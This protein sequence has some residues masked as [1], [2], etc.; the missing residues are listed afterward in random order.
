MDDARPRKLV[1]LDDDPTGSQTVAGVPLL[2]RF[3][4]ADVHWALTQ[5][6]DIVF[7][8]TNSRAMGEDEAVAVTRAVGA[9]VWRAACELGLDVRFLSRGDS[10]LRGHFPAEVEA[11]G[12]GLA[13]AGAPPFDATLL[14]P[15]FPEA[16]RV[17]VGDVHYVERDG[18]R[19]PVAQT[20]FA[21][22]PVFGYASSDLCAWVAE[23]YHGRRAAPRVGHV[24][25]AQVR[26][27]G[28][29]A[30][31]RHL[32]TVGDGQVVVLNAETTE[33]LATL[34]AGARVAEHRGR[35]FA[36]RTGPS[37]VAA[38]AGRATPAPIALP[39]QGDGHGLVVV[40][41]HTALT[42]AQLAHARARHGLREV[43][44]DV[45]ALLGPDGAEGEVA[46]A[47]EEAVTAL[48]E[49]DV[50]LVTSRELASAPDA[51]GTVALK[52]R[53]ADAVVATVE[54]IVARVRPRFVVAKGGITSHDVA[55]RALDSGRATVLGQL[56]PGL[57]SVWR[58][59][60]SRRTPGLPYVVFP[61]NVGGD[62]TLADCIAR[63]DE[64]VA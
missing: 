25:L 21:R 50:A 26:D 19:V 5:P 40:G 31:G 42:T 64:G 27:G 33:D 6:S 49:A 56:F 24:T 54:R 39:A 18:A 38:L 9:R 58:L 36:Y 55:A 14:C 3:D 1:V 34:A 16:G 61:G 48:A 2:L 41:S 62:E 7:A 44:L 13:E 43:E 29:D 59:E 37:F 51:D 35:R 8:L 60:D 52:A 63:L 12:D 47:A 57:V 11:L 30:V 17:T 23:R 32:A 15:A 28:A 4:A 53:I 45:A 46:R 10:T 22:D 20:E